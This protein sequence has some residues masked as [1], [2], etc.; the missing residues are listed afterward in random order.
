MSLVW[1]FFFLFNNFS[2][3]LSFKFL[4]SF[5]LNLC[6]YLA[7]KIDFGTLFYWSDTN[8][9]NNHLL[10]FEFGS[11]SLHMMTSNSF[12]GRDNELLIP[13]HF[14]Y[15]T[16]GFVDLYYVCVSHLLPTLKGL[17]LTHF[18]YGIVCSY[19]CWTFSW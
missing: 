7:L 3:D 12:A 16:P 18:L 4:F 17:S 1:F 9:E 5:S 10:W 8:S 19:G 11:C 13:I 2:A 6:T 15:S 14:L